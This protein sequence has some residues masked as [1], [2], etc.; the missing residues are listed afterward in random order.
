[1]CSL[2]IGIAAVLHLTPDCPI[3]AG[4]AYLHQLVGVGGWDD[5]ALKLK[6]R[7]TG[8][9]SCKVPVEIM[10]ELVEEIEKMIR[11]EGV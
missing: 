4:S 5:G 3:L 11:E 10:D 1:M 2:N 8:K 7:V 9:K 6:S